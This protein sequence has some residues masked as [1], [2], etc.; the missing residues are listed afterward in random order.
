MGHWTQIRYHGQE[1]DHSMEIHWQGRL[2]SEAARLQSTELELE[3]YGNFNG[4]LEN[5]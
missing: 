4:R 5:E 2:A 1:K 3:A